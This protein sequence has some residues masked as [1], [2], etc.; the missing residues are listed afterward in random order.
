MRSFTRPPKVKQNNPV[1]ASE[2]NLLSRAIEE[3][4]NQITPPQK[5]SIGTSA[6]GTAPFWVN[7]RVKKDS[8]P[9]NPVYEATVSL[10][11]V[12]YQNAN[13]EGEGD[14]V[15]GYIVPTISGVKLDA[16]LDN[17]ATE[18]PALPISGTENYVYLLVKTDSDGAPKT[19]AEDIKIQVQT[20]EQT[21]THHVRASPA[22]GET[23]GEYYFLLAETEAT[24]DSDP[25]K[26][27]IKRR[28]TGNRFIPNQ[29]VEI[30][31]LAGDD[32]IAN[33]EFEVYKG[34]KS[35][36]D[37]H[38]M[39]VLKQVGDG[40]AILKPV[41]GDPGSTG[42]DQIKVRSV[43]AYEGGQLSMLPV[44]NEDENIE[45]RGNSY[46]M[47]ISGVVRQIQVLDGLVT[48]INGLDG[49]LNL[50]LFVQ[51]KRQITIPPYWEDT[52]AGSYT[53]YWR[54]GLFAGVYPDPTGVLQGAPPVMGGGPLIS[55]R[56]G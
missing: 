54:D 7:I 29:L 26:P 44:Q 22:S 39:R 5:K 42:N 25:P 46:D 13:L 45:F 2:F 14:G 34:Y 51:A 43:K 4:Q 19:G 37:K 21:S 33:K 47:F 30:A 16:N 56:I 11:Y 12:T 27:R 15:T 35:E 3:L 9:E 20:S 49:A 23:E 24:P 55:K 8:P 50:D 18:I 32:P 1:K 38:E 31:N 53:L 52:T 36:E 48:E 28:I 40:G 6:G 17:P 41:T 10:G